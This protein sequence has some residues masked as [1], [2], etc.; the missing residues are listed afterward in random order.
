M[1]SAALVDLSTLSND[2]LQALHGF[3]LQV[4]GKGMLCSCTRPDPQDHLLCRRWKLWPLKP[5]G[6]QKSMG[7]WGTVRKGITF[8]SLL[9]QVQNMGLLNDHNMTQTLQASLQGFCSHTFPAQSLFQD[10]L[11]PFL[12]LGPLAWATSP[13]PQRL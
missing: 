12:H 7:R 5:L 13:R 8:L 11:Y 10:M 2:T 1:Q 4:S 9:Q 3:L 6:S